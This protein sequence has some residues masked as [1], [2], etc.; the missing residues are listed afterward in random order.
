MNRYLSVMPQRSSRSRWDADRQRGF[1]LLEAAVA[2]M[3]IGVV[4][5]A[6]LSAFAAD[7]RA[8]DQA[9]RM[10][11]AAALAQDRLVA[12]ETTPSASDVLPESLARGRFD[13]PFDAYAWTASVRRLRALPGLMEL[14]VDV[15][16]A[17][18]S[19][20]LSERRYEPPSLT[21]IR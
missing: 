7:L 12:L 1:T 17:S 6:A 14:N 18:G 2:M 4:S 13:A 16:W 20:K 11:P 3:I 5:A 10:L 15:S 19:F 8:A 21:A 9:Q